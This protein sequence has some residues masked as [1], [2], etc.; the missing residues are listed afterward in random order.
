MPTWKTFDAFGREVEKMQRE[1]AQAEKLRIT[2]AMANEAREIGYAAVRE[3]LG[4]LYFS[5]WVPWLELRVKPTRTGGH[6]MTPTRHSAG[7]WTVAE[8]GRNQMSG[9]TI[10][11]SSVSRSGRKK[12]ALG[13]YRRWN[14]QTSGWRTASRALGVMED[15]L[16]KVADDGVRRVMRRHFDVT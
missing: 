12:K 9:P 8:F 7:P 4:D 5:G 1:M 14:G 15:K 16:P 3:D 13:R 10:R 11:E 2:L 6:V